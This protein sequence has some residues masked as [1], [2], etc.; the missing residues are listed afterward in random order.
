[1]PAVIP[2]IA[3]EDNVGD[4]EETG[5]PGFRDDDDDMDWKDAETD[6]LFLDVVTVLAEFEI[7][8]WGEPRSTLVQ[9][10]S[11]PL[12]MRLLLLLVAITAFGAWLV[13]EPKTSPDI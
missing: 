7:C 10:T 9:S 2:V 6:R 1:M 5:D 11:V 4:A 3:D 8:C 13:M 12:M